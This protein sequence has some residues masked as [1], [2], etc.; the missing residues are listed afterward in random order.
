MDLKQIRLDP[1]YFAK[2]VLKIDLHEGQRQV[3]AC[4]SKRICVLAGRKWGKSFMVIVKCLHLAITKANA[5]IL[6]VSTSERESKEMVKR[7]Q[8]MI[9]QSG[10]LADCVVDENKSEIRFANGSEIFAV[11]CNFSTVRGYSNIDLVVLDEAGLVAGEMYDSIDPMGF[12]TPNSQI[13]YIS[14]PFSKLHPFHDQ[15]QRGKAQNNKDIKS[16]HFKTADNPHVPAAELK[17]LKENKPEVI[18]RR[19]YEAQF[20]GDT[21]GL[22]P[23]DLLMKCVRPYSLM[24]YRECPQKVPIYLGIDW[25]RRFDVTC[26]VGLSQLLEFSD[27]SRP[28]DYEPVYFVSAF[29]SFPPNTDWET[30]MQ[31]ISYLADNY[32]IICCVSEPIG[33]GNMAT[34]MLKNWRRFDVKECRTT[35]ALKV[36]LFEKA[37]SLMSAG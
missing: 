34:E 32:D 23:E 26:A 5:R 25:G 27:A 28:R 4:D 37:Y 3:I 30:M 22:F 15:Y 17:W 29:K 6:M 2:E 11:P 10:L 12:C 35:N 7:T 16:F 36:E 33:I 20:V 31:G 8:I 9:A 1:A 18:W 13:I 21:E 14:T 24:H 19:D